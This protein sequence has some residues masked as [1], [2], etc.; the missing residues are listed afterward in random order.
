MQFLDEAMTCFERALQLKEDFPQ[1]Y[2]NMGNVY[3]ARER[4][5]LAIACYQKAVAINPD[6]AEAHTNLGNAFQDQGHFDKAIASYRRSLELRPDFPITLFNLGNAYKSLRRYDDAISAYEKALALKGDL[7]DARI[8]LARAFQ[9]TGARAEAI[10]MFERACASQPENPEARWGLVMTRLALIHDS[11][12]AVVQYRNEFARGLDE[13]ENWFSADRLDSG[14]TAVGSQ[15]PFYLAYHEENNRTVLTRYGA[16]CHRLASH[17]QSARKLEVRK[18]VRRSRIRV[19]IVSAHVCNHS[20][21]HA[22]IKGWCQHLDKARVDL[23]IFSLGAIRDNETDA[24][25]ACATQFVEGHRTPQRWAQAILDHEIDVLIYPEIGMD[26]MAARLA[27]LR[28]AP[29]QAST[30]GHPETSGLPTMDYSISAADF[31]PDDARQNY[32]EQLVVLPH[33]SC[34]YEPLEISAEDLD[35]STL[36]IDKTRPLLICPGTPFKY[37][38][39]HDWIYAEIA[40]K[41]GQ[42]QLLFFQYPIDGLYRQFTGRLETVFSDAGLRLRDFAIEIPWL[43]KPHFN[44]LMR[45]AHVY[46]DTIGFSGFNTAMQAVECGLPIVTLDGRYLRGRLASGVLK[47]MGVMGTVAS[48]EMEY[49]ALAVKLAQDS[50][51]R[52]ALRARIEQSRHLLFNDFAPIRALEEFLATATSR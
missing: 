37:S 5:D 19:G 7:F 3:Q 17:W 20:V 44:S 33:M 50:S 27:N 6:H 23:H 48:T 28:L 43:K 45:Q 9:E 46:L 21:W 18:R 22:L 11:Q 30:W 36:G 12:E 1:A 32:S 16:L 13:L 25:R 26:S 52:L 51:L 38:P 4:L 15:Q 35:L 47:R 8:A 14:F 29:I 24:A 31:E 42:C 2:N 49:V 34:C 39:Q 40:K 41:V 10:A